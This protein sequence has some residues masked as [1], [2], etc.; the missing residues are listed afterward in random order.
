MYKL[1]SLIKDYKNL[2][3]MSEL[4]QKNELR[5]TYLGGKTLSIFCLYKKIVL[6]RF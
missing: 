4:I 5:T 1:L 6:L 3:K 2:P